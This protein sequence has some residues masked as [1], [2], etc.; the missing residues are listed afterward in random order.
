MY[1]RFHRRLAEKLGD[2]MISEIY[3]EQQCIAMLGSFK[4]SP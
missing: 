3:T 1:E 4:S 2:K